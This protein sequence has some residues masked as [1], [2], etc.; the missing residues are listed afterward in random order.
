MYSK[1]SNVVV[2][3]LICVVTSGCFF[4]GRVI[5]TTNA[6]QIVGTWNRGG[7]LSISDVTLAADVGEVKTVSKTLTFTPEPGGLF[8]PDYESVGLYLDVEYGRT[9]TNT[10]AGFPDVVQ[11]PRALT[12]TA[13]NSFAWR[14]RL[15]CDPS[16]AV[17]IPADGKTYTKDTV[18]WQSCALHLD[19]DDYEVIVML[20][21]FGDGRI[22][23]Q[24]ASGT[25]EVQ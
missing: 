24:T 6:G 21:V 10:A 2:Y 16:I 11:A 15:D 13:K 12:L 14:V 7:Q 4:I 1:T 3:G 8:A 19:Q 18:L 9:T 22:N 23:A 5:T 17:G 25:L 20:E